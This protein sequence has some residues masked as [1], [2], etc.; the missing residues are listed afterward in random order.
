MRLRTG[1]GRDASLKAPDAGVLV[2]LVGKDGAAT[3]HRVGPLYDAETTERELQAICKARP[4]QP[5]LS[6]AQNRALSHCIC[7]VVDM[8]GGSWPGQNTAAGHNSCN[9]QLHPQRTNLLSF[10]AR[11]WRRPFV[12]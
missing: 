11:K 9:E 7:R 12:T 4:A 5:L 8:G 10:F 3:L 6:N 2:C 1:F